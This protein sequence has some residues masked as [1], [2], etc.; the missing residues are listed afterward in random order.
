MQ[1]TNIFTTIRTA[2]A[3][4]IAPKP[5]AL[6]VQVQADAGVETAIATAE[7]LVDYEELKASLAGT[8][9]LEDEPDT[10]EAKAKRLFG[11][12]V[13]PISVTEGGED[14]VFFPHTYVFPFKR[15]DAF[16]GVV[17]SNNEA[18][19][20]GLNGGGVDLYPDGRC[21][22]RAWSGAIDFEPNASFPAG[23]SEYTINQDILELY[24][25]GDV[26]RKIY[27]AMIAY[28]REN[29]DFGKFPQLV[30]RGFTFARLK[31]ERY[32]T[33]DGK[34]KYSA[35]LQ[36]VDWAIVDSSNPDHT[37]TYVGGARLYI[38]FQVKKGELPV[39]VAKGFDAAEAMIP[40]FMAKFGHRTSR[41]VREAF[42]KPAEP[43][44]EGATTPAEGIGK[45]ADAG[46]DESKAPRKRAQLF[47]QRPADA[48]NTNEEPLG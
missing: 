15:K 23:G 17:Q 9:A 24:F 19:R 26:V 39:M 3:A 7:P 29:T 14:Y 36:I 38:D 20:L 12:D 10:I 43:S 30:V 5:E 18:I 16:M 13:A 46:V 8:I 44:S 42:A 1:K 37:K 41:K 2:L 6:T 33:Y 31:G 25:D 32:G 22:G 35:Q 21:F 47:Q 28:N 27:D 48:G 4:F 40:A 34:R 45:S 11:R